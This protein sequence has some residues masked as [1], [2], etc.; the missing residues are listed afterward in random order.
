MSHALLQALGL[1]L[2]IEG[3]VYAGAPKAMK[4]MALEMPKLSD[5]QLRIA[6]VMAVAL[7]V[8]VVWLAK[9]LA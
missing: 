9:A 2:V 8:A 7:G 3:L 4:R 5:D 6:G 1:V